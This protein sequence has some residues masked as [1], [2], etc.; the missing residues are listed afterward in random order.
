M[1]LDL[2]IR[3]IYDGPGNRDLRMCLFHWEYFD[4]R[5]KQVA[6][7]RLGTRRR[8]ARR[9]LGQRGHDLH[10]VQDRR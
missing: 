3:G 5:L 10:Q 9:D 8:P 6:S 4:E 2:T 1:D 7:R